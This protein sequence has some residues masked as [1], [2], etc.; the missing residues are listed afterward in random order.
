MDEQYGAQWE[1]RTSE[2]LDEPITAHDRMRQRCP[3]AYSAFLGWSLCEHSNIVSI[4]RNREQI[5]LYGAGVHV[6]PGAPLARMEPRL[7]LDTL[8][9]RTRQI[10]PVPRRAPGRARFPAGGFSSLPVLVT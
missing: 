7:R 1:P 3:V 9:Q 10:A 5:P 8:L 4:V 2:V 6:C